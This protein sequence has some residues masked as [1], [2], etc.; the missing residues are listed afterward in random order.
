MN[1]AFDYTR[2]A[3]PTLAAN[4]P[5]RVARVEVFDDLAS[6]EPAWR[7]L[8]A[9]PALATPY[10]RYDLL[11]VWQR[12]VGSGSGVTPF[13]VVG[14]DDNDEPLFLWPFGRSRTGPLSIVRFLGSKHANFNIGVWRRDL[15]SHIAADDLHGVFETLAA[16]RHGIDLFALSSQ[17]MTWDGFHNPFVHLPHQSAV[18]I[19]ARLTLPRGTSEPIKQV[20]SASMRARL[21]TKERKLQRLAGYRYLCADTSEEIDRLLDAFLVVKARHMAAQGLDNVFAA[22]GVSEFLREAC[23]HR[24]PDGRRLIDIHALEGGDE[25]LALFG[26][27]V[28]AYRASSMFNTYTLG[29][30]SRHSPGLILLVHMINGLAA[31]GI[32]S[33]DIGVGR[34]HYKSFFCPEPEPLFDVF[35]PMTPLGRLAAAALGTA[36]A[37]KRAIKRNRMLWAGV[38]AMRRVRASK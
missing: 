36:C 24:L 21:R 35:L 25:V 23:H 8:E 29:E 18:D 2:S 22:H 10:Q 3:A 37:T 1:V 32:P 13:V 4:R 14:F 6:S 20:L 9:A 30:S 26:S 17:P 16:E 5:V 28:D 15:V 34:A 33:F 27:T 7:R 11:A 38:Q 12:Q 31:R 19:S